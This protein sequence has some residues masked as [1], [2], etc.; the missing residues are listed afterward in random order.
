M[1]SV[2]YQAKCV[3]VLKEARGPSQKITVHIKTMAGGD[4]QGDD[5]STPHKKDVQFMFF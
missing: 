5:H 1:R 2:L 4:R 3:N